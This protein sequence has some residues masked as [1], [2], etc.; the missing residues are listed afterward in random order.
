MKTTK[1]LCDAGTILGITVLDH[2]II[3]E[4]YFSFKA[5]GLI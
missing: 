4:G 2:V 3:G 5:Q 1:R